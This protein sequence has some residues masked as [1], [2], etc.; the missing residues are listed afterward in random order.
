MGGL[1]GRVLGP[2]RR[3]FRARLVAYLLVLSTVTVALVGTVVYARATDDLTVSVYE[4][5]DAIAGI[6]ADALDRWLDEQSRNV[7]FIGVVPGV[8]DDARTLLDATTPGATRDMAEARLRTLLATVVSQT[9]DA[10]EIY[11]LGLDGTVRLSTVAGREG[12]SLANEPLF[13]TGSSNTFVQNIYRSPI[14]GQPTITVA[15]P[16][17]DADPS[18]R[19]RT[20]ASRRT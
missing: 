15:T 4:R 1:V 12:L 13:L 7:V 20:G 18:R 8:G 10:E 16:L 9:A 2:F 11:I 5:L 19:R 3:S 14:T 17:F 6:K